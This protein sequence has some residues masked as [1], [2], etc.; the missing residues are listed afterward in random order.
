MAKLLSSKAL[1]FMAE[2]AIAG[3]SAA[4]KAVMDELGTIMAAPKKIKK[5]GMSSV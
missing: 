5:A 3:L 4:A 1:E 2:A